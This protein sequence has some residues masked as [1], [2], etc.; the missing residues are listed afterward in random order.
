MNF[1][2]IS[3]SCADIVNTFVSCIDAIML[4]SFIIIK[5]GIDDNKKKYVYISFLIQCVLA[6]AL[7]D[8]FIVQIFLQMSCNMIFSILCLKGNLI[9]KII[10][11]IAS[12]LPICAVGVCLVLILSMITNSS[13]EQLTN[14]DVVSL[15]MVAILTRV[16]WLFSY[17]IMLKNKFREMNLKKAEWRIILLLFSVTILLM[18]EFMKL[19]FNEKVSGFEQISLLIVQVLLVVIL[20]CCVTL[21]IKINTVNT[22]L[23]EKE[24]LLTMQ[25]NQKEMFEQVYKAQEE[26]RIIRH[27]MKHFINIWLRQRKEGN[28]ADV[29]NSMESFE[30]QV[31]LADTTVYYIKDNDVINYVLYNKL[32]ICKANNIEYNVEVTTSFAK[33]MEMDISVIISNLM[34][35]A[36]ESSIK[37][38]L[39]ERYISIQMFKRLA[40]NNIIIS[41]K[42]SKSVL[43]ANPKLITTNVDKTR[44]G[45]GIKSVKKLVE[46]YNG[47]IDIVEENNYFIVHIL[48]I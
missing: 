1:I 7:E 20:G 40:I 9:D 23:S 48:G 34:D 43:Q 3:I 8:I 14:G 29:E 4:T 31:F 10:W 47:D 5:L 22:K 28:I 21:C 45:Y 6:F 46:K 33:N 17:F 2:N 13:V 19:D 37:Q 25:E 32:K 12:I 26:T 16:S 41:N 39:G 11:S 27:D 42:I 38:P 24:K 44:H 36:I 30:N 18:C 35:N 15:I